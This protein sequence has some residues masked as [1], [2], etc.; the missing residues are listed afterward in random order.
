MA[1]RF[2]LRHIGNMGDMVFFVPPVLQA[3]KEK[4]PD[5]HITFVTSWGYKE[6]TLRGAV[7]KQLR[8]MSRS[9]MFG[10]NEIDYFWGKRNFGGHSLHLIATNP[11]VDQLVHWHDKRTSLT[12]DICREDGR[13]YQTWSRDYY[14]EQKRSGRYDGV[15]EL[16]FGLAIDED[17][18]KQVMQAVGLP[19]EYF[20]N[21]QLYFSDSDR[22][23]A[24][25]T[26]SEWPRPR[27][28]L[29]E[30]LAGTTT[31]GWNPENVPVLKR[32][33]KER[34]GVEPLEFG[35]ATVPY[36]QGR[37][38]SLRENIATL[39]FCD[40]GIGV[41]S[42]ALHFAAAA[43]LP[44]ITLYGDAPLR[45]TAPGYFLNAYIADKKKKHRTLLGPSPANVR[46][47]KPGKPDDNLTP[48]EVK[49]QGFVDWTKPGKQA[50]KS[51][52]SVITVD[53]VMDVLR[54][55]I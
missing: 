17:P 40:I 41:M 16:D 43:Q 22:K 24:A 13:S 1:K 52:V 49:R 45:R 18:I 47:L 51:C 35:L 3:L 19:S 30:G 36:Y 14:E 33:I 48:A 34:Y 21:Y 44:T 29:L 46:L 8:K 42:G 11:Q 50:T 12:A 32:K 20:S 4:F 15:F 25:A 38:L 5:C 39:K 37:K 28:V 31:R 54:E 26:T 10:E 9:R 53:E 7:R 6:H 23:V 2:L 55:M 27:I